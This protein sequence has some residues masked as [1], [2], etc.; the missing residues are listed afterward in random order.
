MNYTFMRRIIAAW[1]A[2]A[3]HRKAYTA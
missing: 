3:T 2:A 1:M